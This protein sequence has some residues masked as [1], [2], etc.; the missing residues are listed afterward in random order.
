MGVGTLLPTERKKGQDALPEQEAKDT[1]SGEDSDHSPQSVDSK[2]E[3]R[4]APGVTNG[5]FR[6]SNR[7]KNPIVRFGYNEYM[8]HHY[9]FMMK[10]AA[11]QEP[12][13][14]KEAAQ[15]PQ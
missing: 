15:D 5:K 9:A 2:Y 1:T 10:V 4:K 14:Y 13:T 6:Q 8:A 7:Q 11:N 12:E 3:M